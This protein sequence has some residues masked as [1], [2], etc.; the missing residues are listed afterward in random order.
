[1]EA[2]LIR[3]LAIGLLSVAFMLAPTTARAEVAFPYG[4]TWSGNRYFSE[5]LWLSAHAGGGVSYQRVTRT[6]VSD[7]WVLG[8]DVSIGVTGHYGHRWAV[9]FDLGFRGADALSQDLS[10]N[11]ESYSINNTLLG[12]GLQFSPLVTRH[13]E[14]A[15]AARFGLNVHSSSG[16]RLSGIYSDGSTWSDPK[17]LEWGGPECF[18]GGQIDFSVF[19]GAGAE[20]GL[21]VKADYL[22]G[23]GPSEKEDW[24]LD[25]APDWPR[26][27]LGIG[28]QLGYHF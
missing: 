6:I 23:S 20:V 1:M 8:Y 9:I 7:E 24:E 14:I 2:K 3:G 27:S 25:G 4:E 12:L 11:W 26:L 21:T 15:A 19:P 13:F 17:S 18:T 16:R 28:A 22:F 10:E 5:S